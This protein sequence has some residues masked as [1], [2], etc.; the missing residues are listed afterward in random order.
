MIKKD[1]FTNVFLF[2]SNRKLHFLLL[3]TE[4]GIGNKI[5]NSFYDRITKHVKILSDEE[6]EMSN[7][8]IV[9]QNENN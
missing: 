8:L 6:V 5:I 4:I 3:D 1:V 2:N 9:L 7:V